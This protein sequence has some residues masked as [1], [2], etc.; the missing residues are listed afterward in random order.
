MKNIDIK[1]SLELLIKEMQLMDIGEEISNKKKLILIKKA[2]KIRIESEYERRVN[3]HFGY[4]PN[5]RS[6]NNLVQSVFGTEAVECLAYLCMGIVSSCGYNQ[7]KKL[8]AKD[9][10]RLLGNRYR[11]ILKIAEQNNLIKTELTPSEYYSDKRPCFHTRIAVNGRKGSFHRKPIKN[12]ISR[13]RIEKYL[14][15][16]LDKTASEALKKT[17]RCLL[18]SVILSERFEYVNEGLEYGFLIPKYDAFGRRIHS[19]LTNLD[20]RER[21][22]FRNKHFLL[23]LLCEVDAK[24]SHPYLLFRLNMNPYCLTYAFKD[25]EVLRQ[26]SNVLDDVYFDDEFLYDYQLSLDNGTFYSEFFYCLM[27][28]SIADWKGFIKA[29]HIKENPQDK[30]KKFSDIELSKLTFMYVVNGGAKPILDALSENPS[31]EGFTRLIF[32]MQNTWIDKNSPEL[33]GV[34]DY[35][36]H[37]NLPMILQRIES[38]VMQTAYAS[39]KVIWGL[40]LH[41]SIFCMEKDKEA[42]KRSIESAYLDLDLGMPNIKFK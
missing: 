33:K 24:H 37:K 21:A 35:L 5:G 40:L 11:D 30:H 12:Q 22:N 23:S 10:K 1:N 42:V 14:I 41:D 15:E 31:Y 39:E 32:L 7:F 34:K 17:R 29:K 27:E 19:V 2:T 20:R 4:F 3:K 36:P 16:K 38:K 8:S 6:K 18:D 13:A 9:L 26:M 28:D 25:A